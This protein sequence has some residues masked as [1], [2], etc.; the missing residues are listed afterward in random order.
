MRLSLFAALIVLAGSL[1]ALAESASALTCPTVKVIGSV[2]GGRHI[3]RPG[4]LLSFTADVNGLPEPKDLVYKWTIGSGVLLAGQGTPRIEV[5]MPDGNSI[6][7]AVEVE[8]LP[9]GCPNSDSE[10]VA[11]DPAPAAAKLDEFSGPLKKVPPERFANIVKA[12]TDCPSCKFYIFIPGANHRERSAR[13]EVLAERLSIR[14][15][16]GPRIT[17]VDVPDTDDRVTV[18]LVPPGAAPPS[19]SD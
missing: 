4:D 17:Y 11:W 9:S 5:L 13:R 19:P 3:P 16:D 10:T 1:P 7:A 18:W 14:R 12:V 15:H 8:G 6:T 2:V